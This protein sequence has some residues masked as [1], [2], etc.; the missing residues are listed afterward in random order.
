MR[1]MHEYESARDAWACLPLGGPPWIRSQSSVATRSALPGSR[2]PWARRAASA[3]SRAD[4]RADCPR[5]DVQ[6]GILVPHEI[7]TV[8]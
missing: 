2:R 5:L 6:V 4:D 7:R 1:V 8:G 3:G